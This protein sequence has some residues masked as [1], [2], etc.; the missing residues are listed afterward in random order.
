MTDLAASVQLVGDPWKESVYYAD[1]ERWTHLFW[2]EH[3]PFRQL[4]NRLDPSAVLE[5][6]CGHGRHAEKIAPLSKRLVLMDIHEANLQVCRTRL[7]A[8]PYVEFIRNNGFDFQP[9][10]DAALTSLFCYDAMVHFSPDLVE[11]YR[12]DAA[13]VLVPGGMGLFH[14]SNYPAPMNRHYGQNPHARNHMTQALFASYAAA[15]GLEIV[16]SI[17][18]PWGNEPDLDC[19]TLVRR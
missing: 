18:I 10:E 11:S 6:A 1:A 3:T 12:R 9:V 7:A 8:F 5:L 17:V 14:H 15:A 4:F 16:R 2:A 13:R 19:I